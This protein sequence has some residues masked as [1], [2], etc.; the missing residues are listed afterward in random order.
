M[1]VG[2]LREGESR[3]GRTGGADAEAVAAGTGQLQCNVGRYYPDVVACM[4]PYS[5]LL[6]SCPFPFTC[7]SHTDTTNLHRGIMHVCACIEGEPRSSRT[8]ARHDREP[9][10][11]RLL[12][13]DMADSIIH[14]FAN[15]AASPATSTVQGCCNSHRAA[16]SLPL[17]HTG[18]PASAVAFAGAACWKRPLT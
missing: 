17:Y 7:T 3:P 11:L 4:L 6:Q 12:I 15:S 18:K 1:G 16:T 14:R 10:V 2:W 8:D 9:D 13:P 5:I